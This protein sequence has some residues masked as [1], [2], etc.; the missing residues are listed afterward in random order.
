MMLS[1]ANAFTDRTA[2][3]F[4]TIEIE[5]IAHHDHR[6][7]MTRVNADSIYQVSQKRLPICGNYA[8]EV[9]QVF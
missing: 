1:I 8:N 9:T 6:W 5:K 3:G 2:P 4:S 7:K